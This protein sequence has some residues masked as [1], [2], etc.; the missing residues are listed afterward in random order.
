MK[1]NAPK[2]R[3]YFAEMYVAGLFADHGWN[4]YFPRRDE[5]FD[6][7]VTKK[8][9]SEAVIRPVQVKGL[10]PTD[11]KK[12]RLVFGYQGKLSQV[13][14][15][16]VLAIVFFGRGAKEKAPAHVAFMPRS[17]IRERQRGGWRCVPAALTE[18]GPAPR[19]EFQKFFDAAGLT[20]LEE[21]KPEKE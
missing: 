16:M 10:Y 19:R 11:A 15:E 20:R 6:F 17:E 1:G 12:S 21:Q 8:S 5:G 4:V 9:A 13:H 14:G 3:D 7:I 18:D 2:T